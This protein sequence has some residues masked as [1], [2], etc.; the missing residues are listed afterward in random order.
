LVDGYTKFV[1]ALNGDK[2]RRGVK[3][4]IVAAM[5]EEVDLSAS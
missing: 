2:I 1:E 5:N 4:K 3:E